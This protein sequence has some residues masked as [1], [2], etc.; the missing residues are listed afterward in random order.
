[1]ARDRPY[2]GE[3]GWGTEGRLYLSLGA[4][5]QPVACLPSGGEHTEREAAAPG[6]A[7]AGCSGEGGLCAR[8]CPFR[9]SP[10]AGVSVHLSCPGPWGSKAVGQYHATQWT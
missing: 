4:C 7:E 3:E 5:S 10:L 6:C 9:L 2:P 8:P 1:M